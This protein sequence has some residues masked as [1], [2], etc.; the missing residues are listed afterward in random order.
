KEQKEPVL[1]ALFDWEKAYR[2]IPT[3]PNQWPYL[4]VRDFND[5]LLLDTRITFGG[6]AGCGSFGRPA[7]AWKKIM[8]HEFEVLTIFC[9]VDNNLFIKKMDSPA[10]MTDVVKR[11]NKLGV[12]TNKEKYSP[13]L[14]EQKF[15][16]FIW[17]GKDKTVRLT[18]P[19]RTK[20]PRLHMEWEGQD[21]TATRKEAH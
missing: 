14:E 7:D 21:S 17:N 11:S 16:G 6:V 5:G 1:L 8:M 13:F 3:A 19:R 15:L 4:M 12:K 2:Q 10:L 9:W 20:V 18:F